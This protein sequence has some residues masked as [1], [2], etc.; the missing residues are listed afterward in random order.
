MQLL[1][2]TVLLQVLA[3]QYVRE[4][5]ARRQRDSREA[6]GRSQGCVLLVLL[7]TAYCLLFAANADRFVTVLLNISLTDPPLLSHRH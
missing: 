3:A 6:P 7:A 4:R 1:T 5:L 2:L